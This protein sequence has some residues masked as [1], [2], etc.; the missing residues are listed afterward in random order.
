[1][2]SLQQIDKKDIS[3]P[4]ELHEGEGWS[5]LNERWKVI[6]LNKSSSETLPVYRIAPKKKLRANLYRQPVKIDDRSSTFSVTSS[7]STETPNCSSISI[8]SSNDSIIPN[9]NSNAR[10]KS[11]A[12]DCQKIDENFQYK[13]NNKLTHFKAIDLVNPVIQMDSLK[14][15]KLP[16]NNFK[17]ISDEDI[18]N[19]KNIY[20]IQPKSLSRD[21][22]TGESTFVPNDHLKQSIFSSWSNSYEITAN[23]TSQLSSSKQEKLKLFCHQTF[24]STS[25]FTKR[26]YIASKVLV[27]RFQIFVMN[28]LRLKFTELRNQEYLQRK[29]NH[30]AI[31]EHKLTMDYHRNRFVKNNLQPIVSRTKAKISK[32]SETIKLKVNRS[33]CTC[34]QRVVNKL[35]K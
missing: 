27:E 9:M 1:M 24:S 29:L 18:I 17:S 20:N 32:S 30:Q 12:S 35:Q 19:N 11:N 28:L 34:A 22:T 7:T 4:V 25:Q 14:S 8:I 26:Y 15:H 5:T 13:K 31:I 6:E 33:M 21:S 2:I 23:K 3:L 10:L 16:P